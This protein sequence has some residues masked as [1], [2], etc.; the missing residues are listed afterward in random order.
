[1]KAH[2]HVVKVLAAGAG[3]EWH[4]TIDASMLHIVSTSN[5]TFTMCSI[6]P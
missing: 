6:R 3:T 2:G 4:G 1:M 5:N